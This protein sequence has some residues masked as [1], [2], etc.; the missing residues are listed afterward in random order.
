MRLVLV[1]PPM[2]MVSPVGL[3]LMFDP[4]HQVFALRI[5]EGPPAP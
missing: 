4:T 2:N 3:P 1:E 5:S